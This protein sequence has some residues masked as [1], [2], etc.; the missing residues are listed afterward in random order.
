MVNPN[1]SF[2]VGLCASR[3][4]RRHRRHGFRSKLVRPLQTPYIPP[5]ADSCS[6]HGFV[7][8]GGKGAQGQA[9]SDVWVITHY[10]LH[11]FSTIHKLLGIRFYQPIL[12]PSF[13]LI[14]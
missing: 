12:V 4:E 8:I 7:V 3:Q 2:R 1:P 14:Q 5:H 13:C 6:R 11:P 9:L 10:L